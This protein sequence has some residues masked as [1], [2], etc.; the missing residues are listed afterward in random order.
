M[1][2]MQGIY[3]VLA[4]R[5]GGVRRITSLLAVTLLRC[6]GQPDT[7]DACPGSLA[8]SESRSHAACLSAVL[9]SSQLSPYCRPSISYIKYQKRSRRFLE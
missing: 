1:R 8:D 9:V 6:S 7:H 3:L 4:E 5:M 2:E